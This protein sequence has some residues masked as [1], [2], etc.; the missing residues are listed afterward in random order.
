MR[1]LLLALLC[2]ATAC[3]GHLSRAQ[4]AF[5]EG[6]AADAV[7]EFRALEPELD[8]LSPRARA[9]YALHRGLAHLAC[10]DLRPAASWLARARAAGAADPRVFD[11]GEHGK[12]D[13]AWRAMGLMPGEA[14]RITSGLP[15]DVP[16]RSE[17]PH[18]SR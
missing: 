1:W 3:G 9:R 15:A 5:D 6:R 13:A 8:Q 2:L 16:G 12:L 11:V 4:H 18:A 7:E 14:A 10:G 17:P